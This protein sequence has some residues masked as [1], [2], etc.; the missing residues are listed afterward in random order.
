MH[1]ETN[2]MWSEVSNA[3]GVSALSGFSRFHATADLERPRQKREA[4]SMDEHP[5]GRQGDEEPAGKRGEVDELV[6][7]SGD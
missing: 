5:Q 1:T 7:L 3:D 4:V 6:D 2:I